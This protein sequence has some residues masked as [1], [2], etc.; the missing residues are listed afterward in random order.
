MVCT[1]LYTW[2][3]CEGDERHSETG[4]ERRRCENSYWEC[5][6]HERQGNLLDP[7]VASLEDAASISDPCPQLSVVSRHS[8]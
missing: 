7:T 2:T 3:S 8:P 1:S 5:L 4:R 6:L